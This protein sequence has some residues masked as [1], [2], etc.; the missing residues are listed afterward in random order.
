MELYVL[1]ENICQS[2]Y[3]EP[4][5]FC[6]AEDASRVVGVFST[7]ERAEAEKTR[8]ESLVKSENAEQ[9]EDECDL[10]CED[11]DEDVDWDEEEDEDNV[12]YY[13]IIPCT[14]DKILEKMTVVE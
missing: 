2:E 11:E 8:L 7:R 6:A 3:T 1:T 4:R 14:L 5:Y 13:E 10:P 12:P 9:E